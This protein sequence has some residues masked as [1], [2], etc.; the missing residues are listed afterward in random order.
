[1]SDYSADLRHFEK[2][3]LSGSRKRI[4]DYRAALQREGRELLT[5]AKARESLEQQARDGLSLEETA[6]LYGVSP[7]A[8]FMAQA[9][10]M[11]GME[12]ERK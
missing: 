7:G 8:L 12:E 10:F 3:Y 4:E 6:A 9:D 5:R 11:I 1:M 2:T